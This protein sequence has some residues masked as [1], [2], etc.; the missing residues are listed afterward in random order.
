[1]SEIRNPEAKEKSVSLR[2]IAK[3][4]TDIIFSPFRSPK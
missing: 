4:L 1:M 2:R 3:F